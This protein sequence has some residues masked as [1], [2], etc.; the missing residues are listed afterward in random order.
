MKRTLK[1]TVGLAVCI[2]GL[3]A[4]AALITPLFAQQASQAV[5][6]AQKIAAS[7]AT[8]TV[9]HETDCSCAAGTT[10]CPC[11]I[12]STT[13][14]NAIVVMIEM[15]YG[16]VG[17]PGTVTGVSDGTAYTH[18]A[19]CRTINVPAGVGVDAY[20]RT[21]NAGGITTVTATGS[22]NWNTYGAL[23]IYE[24]NKSSGTISEDADNGV[25][26]GPS[27]FT[28]PTLTIGAGPDIVFQVFNSGASISTPY[29]T[30]PYVLNSNLAYEPIGAGAAYA[31]AQTSYAQPTWTAG[32]NNGAAAIA[33]K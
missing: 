25:S 4:L 16:L 7:G 32:G 20:F 3:L 12:P 11:T 8:W 21:T 2:S 14:G 6:I 5:L 31:L 24:V 27:V 23:F 15:G 28:G 17:G 29:I 10:S 13:A 18:C 22:T 9:V 33:F 26:N 19:N 30:S 1:L